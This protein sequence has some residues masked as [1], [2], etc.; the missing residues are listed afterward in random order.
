MEP[1]ASA[2]QAGIERWVPGMTAQRTSW[3]VHLRA[4]SGEAGEMVGVPAAGPMHDRP[5]PRPGRE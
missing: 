5:A 2:A 1:V 4:G 3:R